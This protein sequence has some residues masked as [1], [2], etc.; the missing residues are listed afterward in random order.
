MAN[1][2]ICCAAQAKGD[3]GKPLAVKYVTKT[4][5]TKIRC[6]VCEVRPSCSDQSKLVFAFRFLKN[7]ACGIAGAASCAPTSAGVAQYNATRTAAAKAP[8]VVY[9]EPSFIPVTAGEYPNLVLGN[10]G[11]YQLPPS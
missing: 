1:K 5:E 7:M 3:L 11:V 9:D 10:R 6:G 8:Q 4:G 2:G